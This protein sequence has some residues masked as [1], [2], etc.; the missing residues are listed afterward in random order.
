MALEVGKQKFDVLSTGNVGIGSVLPGQALDVQGSIRVFG[1]NSNIG[2]DTSYPGTQLDVQGTVRDIN[3]LVGG[4][5]GIGTTFI[6]SSGESALTVM[7]GNV[8][9]GTWLPRGQLDVQGTTEL[10]YVNGL[11]GIGTWLPA[12][13]LDLVNKTSR[14]RTVR[15]VVT[16]AS[17]ATPAIDTD[18]TDLAIINGL[19]TPITNMSTNL[20]G[21]PNNGDLIEIRIID[22]GTPQAITWGASFVA[23]LT[24]LPTTTQS[25]TWIRILFEW[26]AN[27]T[28][29]VWE[30]MGV[31]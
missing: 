11:V 20:T 28:T 22:N 27:A 13:D 1:V 3:E 26:N 2:I 25:N 8:G 14:G 16:V 12:Y 7:D 18:I 10:T 30:C 9:I 23:T 5:I 15:R 17:S 21:T 31:T 4:N 29:P 19:A 6:N 24:A